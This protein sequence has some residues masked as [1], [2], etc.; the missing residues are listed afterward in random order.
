MRRIALLTFLFIVS[1]VF[2]ASI[3]PAPPQIGADAYLLVDF[4]SGE[5]L[6]EHN[7]DERLPPASLTKLMTAYILA[8]EVD[9]GRLNL[10]DNVPVSRNAW[11]QNPT[12][13]GSSLMWIEPN[14]PVSVRQLEQGIV[15]SSG[16]DATVCIAEHIAGTEEAFAGMMN[17]YAEVLGMTSTHFEN[18]HGLPHPD[19]LTTARDLATLASATIRNHPDRYEV[20]KQQS[21]TYNDITQYNRNHLLREDPTVDGLKT[22]YTSVAGY[23]LVASAKR[24]GMRLVSVVLGSKSTRSRKAETRSL[25]NYGFRFY[26]TIEPLTAELSLGQAKVWKGTSK[27]VD[28]G[29]LESEVMTVPRSSETPEVVAV[30]NDALE[31]PI[32]RGDAI[33]TVTVSRGGEVLRDLPLVALS[34]VPE[35]GFFARL[36]DGFMLWL[37]QLFG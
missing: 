7:A 10:D 23:G 24:E 36:W 4:D 19:H 2:A 31:A 21:Y 17:R 6:V 26:Q 3:V 8:E 22:G 27:I 33:G 34:D 29:V 9:A 28:G 37:S 25:L 11:S 12:F 5:V 16:N 14:K 18:S 13:R 32:S 1:P 20:Y 15:I 30:F 35:A